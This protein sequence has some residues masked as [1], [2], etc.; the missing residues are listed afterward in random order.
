[1][2]AGKPADLTPVIH[3]I[4]EVRL[5]EWPCRIILLQTKAVTDA[6]DLSFLDP[7]LAGRLAWPDEVNRLGDLIKE[8]E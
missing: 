7:H 6:R 5:M 2:V 1:M 3:L 4:Q 8:S